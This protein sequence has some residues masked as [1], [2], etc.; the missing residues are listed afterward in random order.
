MKTILLALL[1]A[2]AG[3][4]LLAQ[5]PPPGL[6]T[7]P[8]VRRFPRNTNGAALPPRFTPP[9]SLPGAPGA[10][11]ATAAASA[12]FAQSASAL[13]AAQS[14][15]TIPAGTINFQGVDVNQVLEVYAQLVGRTLLHAALPDAKIVL[16]TQTPLT[17][18]EAIQALQAVLA[19]NGI[20]LVNIGD[21]FV[22]VLASDQAGTAGGE[23]DR[24][25]STN[26]PNLGTYVTHIAQLKFVKPSE[27]IPVIQPFSKLAN[28]ILAIDSNR[29]LVIRDYAENVKRMLEM[30]EQIDVDVPAEYISEVIPIR[31]AKV[32][33]I[34]SAL[35]S[36]SGSGGATVSIGSSAAPSPIS[37][38]RGGGITGG[39]GGGGGSYGGSSYGS[40]MSSMGGI[41]SG[42][43]SYNGSSSTAFGNRS[44]GT[45]TGGAT[46]NGTPTTGSTFASRL[47][48]IINRAGGGS[49]TGSGTQD[50]IVLFGQTKIIPNLSSS[51]LLIYATRP[52]ME[53]IKGIIAK[54]DVPLAQVL[55]EALIIDYTLGDKFSFGVS[56]AQNPKTFWNQNNSTNI[57]NTVAGAGGANNGQSFYNFAN[58]TLGTNAS[59][60]SFANNLGSGF[61]YFGNIGPTWDVAVNAAQSDSHA[62]IIQRPRIQT[63]QAQPAQF[64]VGDTV[65]YVTGN[66]YGS[67]YGNSSSYSQLSVGVEL[68]VTP[69]INPEGA[70][71][72]QI[73]QEIDD[74]NGTTHIDNVGDI[75]NTIK[76]TLNTTITVRDKDTVMLGGFIKSDKNHS[77][78]GIPFLSDIP[79]L[80]NLFKQRSDSK[81]RE[82]LI[83]LMRPTVLGTPELAAKQTVKEKQRLPGIS[84]AAAEESAE[85]RKLIDVQRK[86]E[87][88][89][90]KNTQQYDGFFVPPPDEDATTNAVPVANPFTNAP[91]T[92][93]PATN[94]LPPPATVATNNAAPAKAR[95]TWPGKLR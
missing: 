60:S 17:K 41:G 37:G 89:E 65:P 59:S 91:A 62:S 6:P 18:S 4:D 54:L 68:D 94:A 29:I 64:F 44:L 28:S 31:Y 75:P 51:T 16:K 23:V 11:G 8:A 69:F 42:T 13:L 55:V 40:G 10:P 73:Q 26:L 61:S 24:S 76:R 87:Q 49:G 12:A 72:M 25:G 46:A 50:Q 35:N 22:K 92:N 63:S 36:L 32:D 82:E 19:L 95:A 74:L 80:G 21:K 30:I 34:A 48:N 7:M 38:V 53:V 81:N 83:V 79:L 56:A 15:E 67:T 57:V 9:G 27:M 47:N 52:D 20:S 45:T 2:L 33:D 93:A 84:Q 58:Q 71:T 85:E 66:T 14:E 1:L 88:K 77:Q 5:T 39:L 86:R 3:L 78:S 70:V 43:S 90:F